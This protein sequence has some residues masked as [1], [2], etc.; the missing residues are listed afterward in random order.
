MSTAL[1]RDRNRV[2]DGIGGEA[3]RCTSETG[4]HLHLDV[5]GAPQIHCLEGHRLRFVAPSERLQGPG[6]EG[7]DRRCVASLAELAQ[8]PVPIS[9]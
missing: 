6:E 5:L 1:T 4:V 2:V 3:G 9:Q 7:C 8:C